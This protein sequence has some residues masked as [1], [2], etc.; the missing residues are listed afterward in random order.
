MPAVRQ[1][2]YF[3]TA[4][5]KPDLTIVLDLPAKLFLE[6]MEERRDRMESAVSFLKK[7]RSAYRRLASVTRKTVIVRADRDPKIIH[8]QLVGIIEGH[9]RFKRLK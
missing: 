9:P 5:L 4:G 2:D 8:Q 3:A 1:I 6:R 7:V